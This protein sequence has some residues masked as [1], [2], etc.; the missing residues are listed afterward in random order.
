MSGDA[1]GREVELAHD[2]AARAG[3]P[4]HAPSSAAP[5]ASRPYALL[6][7]Q[8]TA[9]NR[10]VN[11]LLAAGLTA[12]ARAPFEG[13]GAVLPPHV[14]DDMER[15][16]GTELGEVRVHTDASAAGAARALSANAYT[17]GHDIVFGEGRFAPESA[18]GSRLLA[19][20]LAHVV[21]QRRGGTAPSPDPESSLER[22][23]DAA[24]DQVA[25][26]SENVAVTGAAGIGIARDVADGQPSS[27]LDQL[28][29][30]ALASPW[31]PSQAKDAL[32]DANRKLDAMLQQADPSGRLRE[33]TKEAVV[34]AAGEQ[35]LDAAQK[36][37][38]TPRTAAPR[39]APKPAAP[40]TA[41]AGTAAPATSASPPAQQQP[42]TPEQAQERADDAALAAQDMTRQRLIEY[43]Q[44]TAGD[45]MDKYGFSYWWRFR[46]RAR[47]LPGPLLYRV[48]PKEDE[49]QYLLPSG[50]IGT[51][52]DYRAERV[53]SLPPPPSAVGLAAGGVT[54]AASK[55]YEAVTGEQVDPRYVD[56]A[57]AFGDLA[58]VGLSPLAQ[59]RAMQDLNT[60]PE[61]RPSL[62]PP[63]SHVAG[64]PQR[65]SPAFTPTPRLRTPMIPFD[66]ASAEAGE[67]AYLG[68]GG[69]APAGRGEGLITEPSGLELN[70]QWSGGQGPQIGERSEAQLQGSGLNVRL[71]EGTGAR[72]GMFFG[73]LNAAEMGPNRLRF[74]YDREARR[75]SAVQYEVHPEPVDPATGVSLVQRQTDRSFTQDV[76]VGGQEGSAGGYLNSGWDK[77]HLAQREAFR[78]YG[79]AER[80]ADSYATTVPMAPSLNRGADSPWR[81]AE[82]KTIQWS[83]QYNGVKVTVEPIYGDPGLRLSNGTPI[84]TAIRRRVTK[85]DGSAIDQPLA[86]VTFLNR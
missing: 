79:P 32:K 73:E 80:A 21:Q 24:A 9:G 62:S 18:R 17:V 69:A 48:L 31:L 12:S 35:R 33:T 27:R 28:Y 50:R 29:Q 70:P 10:A 6:N 64:A 34:R 42:L 54:W 78:G 84:P 49:T 19:H 5:A 1:R 66:A 57:M 11:D 40:A 16:F 2:T 22:H 51:A 3:T 74:A 8:R 4:S 86:D 13:G 75:P 25:G 71:A 63:P 83:R 26:G 41:P 81:E 46:T 55:G 68:R 47:A 30:S 58:E 59:R 45:F 76:S 82:N 53:Q 20:E 77:G 44:M 36:M 67:F 52:S 85:L 15:R 72:K 65:A 38:E 43:S 60:G 37:L 14:R 61:W 23:A 56:I 39:P 7:L